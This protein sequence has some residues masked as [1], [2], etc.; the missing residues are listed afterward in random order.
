MCAND[1]PESYGCKRQDSTDLSKV[2]PGDG[3]SVG[4]IGEVQPRSD[5]YRTTRT[6]RFNTRLIGRIISL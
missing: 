4:D 3:D 6:T 5:V 2:S 1:N